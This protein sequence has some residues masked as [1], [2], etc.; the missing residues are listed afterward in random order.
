MDPLRSPGEKEFQVRTAALVKA[1]ENLAVAEPNRQ[2]VFS[3][4]QALNDAGLHLA[5]W[6]RSP[7]RSDAEFAELHALDEPPPSPYH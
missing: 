7:Q 3:D 6:R 2:R 4:Y 1:W 5:R